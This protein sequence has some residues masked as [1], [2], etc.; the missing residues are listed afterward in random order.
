MMMIS[1]LSSD[2]CCSTECDLN[3]TLYAGK[4]ISL[5]K[6]QTTALQ[7]NND[8]VKWLCVTEL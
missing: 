2:V 8:N 7:H 4:I 3:S 6:D 5:L 1:S